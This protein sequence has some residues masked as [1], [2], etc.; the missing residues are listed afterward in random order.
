MPSHLRRS[1]PLRTWQISHRLARPKNLEETVIVEV[2]LSPKGIRYLDALKA[3]EG[4]GISRSEI[5]RKFVWDSINHLIE[6]RRLDEL[7]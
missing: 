7:D 5:V 6:V 1:N 4:F 2:R 3:K